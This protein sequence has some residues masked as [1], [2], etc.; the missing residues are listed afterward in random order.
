MALD[1]LQARPRTS[2]L[3]SSWRIKVSHRATLD[4]V[5]LSA[6]C[7]RS[8]IS[9]GRSIPSKSIEESNVYL[10]SSYSES[11]RKLIV[12]LWP[13]CIRIANLWRHDIPYVE[14][15]RRSVDLDRLI[16]IARAKIDD[17]RDLSPAA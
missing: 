17:S 7:I 5:G 12:E 2:K 4:G 16:D 6:E 9:M 13:K 3:D 1:A 8:E 15:D 11:K 14:L 10:L